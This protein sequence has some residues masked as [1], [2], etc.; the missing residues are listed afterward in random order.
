MRKLTC[1]GGVVARSRAVAA[2]AVGVS[3]V[4]LAAAVPVAS[5]ALHPGHYILNTFTSGSP[6]GPAGGYETCKNP[7]TQRIVTGGS[8]FHA[9]GQGPDPNNAQ[10]Y[11]IGS[12]AATF[13][14][15]GWYAD[16]ASIASYLT[17]TTQCLPKSQ[18]GTYS[19]RKHTFNVSSG[20][21]GGGY[22]KCPR[23]QRIVTG[24]AFWH[25]AHQG[26]D[27]GTDPGA[28]GSSSATFDAKGWYADGVAFSSAQLTITALCLPPSRIGSYTLKHITFKPGAGGVAGGYLKCPKK[29]GIVAGG[30][31]WHKPG[32][33]PDPN[34]AL[35]DVLGSS[36]ATFD[37]K[38]WYADGATNNTS[39][40]LTAVAQCLPM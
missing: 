23:G 24:G 27:P 31:F 36:A 37:A 15:K 39:L 16:G 7:K 5:A 3:V 10:T 35:V 29:Q 19:L 2:L 34:N 13:D 18:V 21:T 20:H 38:G 17:I 40:Q 8:F 22:V 11:F 25:F 32:K 12:S 4:V 33:G 6:G 26:P 30:A 1:S 28:L 9:L 14:A